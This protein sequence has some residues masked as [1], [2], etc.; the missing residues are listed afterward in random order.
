M[1]QGHFIR[2]LYLV[3]EVFLVLPCQVV[4]FKLGARLHPCTQV[5]AGALLGTPSRRR[6]WR[7]VWKERPTGRPTPPSLSVPSTTRRNYER[8]YK[9]QQ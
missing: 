9:L 6:R 7:V 1:W 8:G 3:F 2:V 4:N 5:A